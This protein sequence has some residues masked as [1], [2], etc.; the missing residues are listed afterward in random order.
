MSHSY[1]KG[2]H[3]L[4]DGVW[5]YIQ[6]DGSW[7]LSNAGLIVGDGTSLLVDTLMDL[8]LTREMLDSM[9]SIT[10]TRPIDTLVNTHANG[11][12][13][14]GNELVPDRAEIYAT[15]AAAE[16]M[17]EVPPARLLGMREAE[18]PELREFAQYCF[19]AFAIEEVNGRP[20]DRTFTDSLELEVGGRKVSVADLGPAHTH[21]DSIVYLADARTV[22]TGDLVFVKGT[23]IAWVGPIG[24]WLAA[25]DRI[26]ALDVDTVVP[27]HGPITDKDGVR[28]V[29]AYF[30][31]VYAEAK[32]RQEAGVDSLEAAFDI[33]LGPFAEWGD[34][35]RIVVTVDTIY[36]ELD[37][38]HATGEPTELF[39]Q[40]GRYMKK[41]APQPR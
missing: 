14:Y 23:P 36:G 39:R 4:G 16:E 18:D 38:S 6:P 30:S 7:C 8:K 26:C 1:T 24:N 35:E 15:V 29:H 25:C 32:L 13:C 11:D 33:D 9:K 31:H 22:F 10:A 3:E 20:P 17:T 12:H 34:S 40:M 19:G 27:G 37:P 5:A 2:L 41:A 21:S 28:D